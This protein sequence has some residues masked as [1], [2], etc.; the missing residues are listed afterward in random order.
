MNRKEKLG[1]IIIIASSVFAV[2]Y[3]GA[4]FVMTLVGF[5]VGCFLFL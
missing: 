1:L 4:Y 2:N 3:T 5:I